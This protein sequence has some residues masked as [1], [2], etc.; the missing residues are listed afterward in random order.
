[1][2]ILE[3]IEKRFEYDGNHL[4]YR[5]TGKQA[6]CTDALGYRVV[7]VG[8]KKYKEHR[9]VWL[10]ANK[11]WPEHQ[12]DHINRNRSDNRLCNLRDVNQRQNCRNRPEKNICYEASRGKFKVR[13]AQKHIGYFDDLDAA[14]RARDSAVKE[15]WQ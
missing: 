6:G 8:G 14:I 13:L 10:L 11:E 7:G 3:T 2:N 15:F 1:M 12:I 5:D 4:Y 9:L